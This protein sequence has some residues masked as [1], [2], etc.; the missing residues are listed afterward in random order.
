MIIQNKVGPQTV[1]ASLAPGTQIDGR[2]GQMGDIIVSKLQPEYY[3]ATYRKNCFCAANQA[4]RVT[5]V[6]PAA[7]YNG[8]L[9]A[10][11]IGS[12]INAALLF[13]GYSFPVAAPADI[14]VGLG[15]G[16]SG[17][18]NVTHNG[19]ITPRCSFYGSTATP[20][21]T[22]DEVVTTL[23]SVPILAKIFGKVDSGIITTVSQIAPTYTDLKG[24]VILP[25]GAYAFIWTSTVS[26]AVGFCGSFDWME[27][28][29]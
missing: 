11:P 22:I 16:Y 19:V 15:L 6:G 8:L 17:S 23:P 7:P 10:N 13:V 12:T 1:T 29:I 5:T 26:A 3:E 9:I 24:Q 21:C 18:T 14:V 25:P 4:N 20:Q 2:A 27:I 28:P